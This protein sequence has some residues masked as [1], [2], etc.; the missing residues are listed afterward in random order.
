VSQSTRLLVLGVV[1]IFQPVHG[2]DVRRELLSWRAEEWANVSAGSVYNAL[3]SLTKDGLIEI[4][5]S[6]QVGGRPE[7]TSYRLTSDGEEEFMRLLRE[8]WWN[9]RAPLD[10]LL[11][12]IS[13]LWAM[14]REELIQALMHRVRQIEGMRTHGKFTRAAMRKDS[15]PEH[16]AEMMKLM[17][18]RIASEIAWA[19]DLMGRLAEGTYTTADDPPAKRAKLGPK[20]RRTKKRA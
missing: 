17:D 5:G 6:G 16:V 8:S 10:P 14:D 4:V 19:H 12:A 1:R 13:F 11:P 9:V 2:Y 3:K 18:A 7:R 20:P 15:T